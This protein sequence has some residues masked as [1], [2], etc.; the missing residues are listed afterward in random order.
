MCGSRSRRVRTWSHTQ[1]HDVKNGVF[2]SF[3]RLWSKTTRTARRAAL[4]TTYLW[5]PPASMPTTCSASRRRPAMG[6]LLRI[7]H[8][9]AGG[10]AESTNCWRRKASS[11]AGTSTVPDRGLAVGQRA[12]RGDALVGMPYGIRRWSMCC[13]DHRICSLGGGARGRSVFMLAQ[14]SCS[15]GVVLARRYRA[16]AALELALRI[17][18]GSETAAGLQWRLRGHCGRS[19]RSA[20]RRRKRRQQTLSCSRGA[21]ARSA[22]RRRKLQQ[23]PYGGGCEQTL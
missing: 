8:F 6:C 14:R 3:R 9:E 17:G 7:R 18:G 22:H 20:H 13:V 11:G 12:V 16:R 23:L 5:L 1:S 2:A 10:G 15:L 4:V 21:R 19:A